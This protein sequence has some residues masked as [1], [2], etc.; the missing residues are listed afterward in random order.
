LKQVWINESCV[1]WPGWERK[2]DWQSWTASAQRFSACFPICDRQP[3]IRQTPEPRRGR[4]GG[5][6]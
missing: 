1:D 3:A 5:D 4:H 6:A 2:P